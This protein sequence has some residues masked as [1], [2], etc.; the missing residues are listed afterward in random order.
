MRELTSDEV[1]NQ[2]GAF[3][4]SI[5]ISAVCGII[6]A[7]TASVDSFLRHG[8]TFVYIPA[9]FLVLMFII[10]C[11]LYRDVYL[12]FIPPLILGAIVGYALSYSVIFWIKVVVITVGLLNY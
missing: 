3:F 6:I 12:A 10:Y 8:M 11:F 4:Y 7:L 1:G 9:I 2:A 5:I